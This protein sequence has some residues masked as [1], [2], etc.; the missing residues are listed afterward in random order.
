M[1]LFRSIPGT[2][3]LVSALVW[4]QAL[5][6]Q[7]PGRQPFFTVSG[8][9]SNT[10]GPEFQ[11]RGAMTLDISLG[12]MMKQWQHV[13]MTTAAFTGLTTKH[14]SDLTCAIVHASNGHT[15][16]AP[17]EPTY[18]YVGGM[19]GLRS[20]TQ[21]V[22]LSATAG[23]ALVNS[24]CACSANPDTRFGGNA[25][26]VQMRAEMGVH[27]AGPMWLTVAGQNLLIPRLG[28]KEF[29]VQGLNVGLHFQ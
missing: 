14:G 10:M 7:A 29:R 3:L 5:G 25:L 11:E 19:A 17:L 21:P 4:S 1:T 9:H 20:N 16:C 26:G 13:S 6:A 15:Y 12:M 22:M 8:G 24:R 2:A 27:A 23:P 28:G 18:R